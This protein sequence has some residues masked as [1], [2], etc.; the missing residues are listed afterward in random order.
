MNGKP[1]E[2]FPLYWPEGRPRAPD[3]RR[4]R[5][6]FTGTFAAIRS[7]LCV[8][9][10][11]MGAS[12]VVISSNLPLR[13]DGL[14]RAGVHRIDDPGIAVYFTYKKQEMCFACDKYQLVWE[15]M[16]AISKTI[17]AIRGIERWGSS[18]MMERAFRGFKALPEKTEEPWRNVFGFSATEIITGEE[19]DRRFRELA[20][21]EH[22]DGGGDA[23][24]FQRVTN[25]RS[26][27]R[28]AIGLTS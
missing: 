2:A 19:I 4:G 28:R 27:A 9:L 20:R 12:R 1:V 13:G 24:R 25:A 11:R 22:P 17:D 23:E 6:P 8:E 7:E 18:D 5:S 16:R 3:G 14:P 21:T 10:A 15:N 26:D